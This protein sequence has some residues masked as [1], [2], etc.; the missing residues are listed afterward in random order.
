[1]NSI[2]RTWASGSGCPPSCCFSVQRT[3]LR[4]HT[5]APGNASRRIID[6]P[7]YP[8]RVRLPNKRSVLRLLK[9]ASNPKVI[10]LSDRG[11]AR[12]KRCCRLDRLL[13]WR[14][15]VMPR[16]KRKK[17]AFFGCRSDNHAQGSRATVFSQWR[18]SNANHERISSV[19][20]ICGL[21]S[22]ARAGADLGK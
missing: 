6:V 1:M 13:G 14:W 8:W 17:V 19:L 18:S 21:R 9:R 3:T 16:H 11:T 10:R 12:A 5:N 4:S 2:A 7:N 20:R 15:V 22:H